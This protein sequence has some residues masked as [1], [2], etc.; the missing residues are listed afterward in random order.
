MASKKGNTDGDPT[1]ERALGLL[2]FRSRSAKELAKRL[3]EKGEP[4][5]AIEPVIARL[6]ANGLLDDARYAEGRARV[7]IV[8]KAR[9]RRRIEQE[10]V[11]RGVDRELAGEAVLKVMANEGT[12]EAAVAEKAARKKLRT[13]SRHDEATKREKLYAYL[14]RQG[15]PGEVVRRAVRVALDEEKAG[16]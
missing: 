3:K 1:Y 16:G 11:Q 4:V 2:S 14:A 6:L 10:L 12:D 15:Y 13:L 7:G 5:E 8:G 9:S